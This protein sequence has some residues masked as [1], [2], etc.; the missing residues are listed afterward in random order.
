MRP[1]R[2]LPAAK[3]APSPPVTSCSAC[4][5]R[6]TPSMKSAASSEA[7]TL[8][9]SPVLVQYRPMTSRPA[10]ASSCAACRPVRMLTSCS[11]DGPPKATA[12][13]AVVTFNGGAPELGGMEGRSDEAL[14]RRSRVVVGQVVLVQHHV[15]APEVPAHPLGRLVARASTTTWPDP[16]PFVARRAPRS[17]ARRLVRPTT[18]RSVATDSAWA[19]KLSFSLAWTEPSSTIPGVTTTRRDASAPTRFRVARAARPPAG[20]AL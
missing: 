18:T 15:P 2:P 5:P 6:G 10:P 8:C 13:L 4:A 17:R 20:L 16:L 9:Q 1:R 12:T 14:R 3:P 19:A 7:S 11:G